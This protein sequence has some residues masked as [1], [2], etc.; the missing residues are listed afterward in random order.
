MSEQQFDRL[1]D[2]LQRLEWHDFRAVEKPELPHGVSPRDNPTPTTQRKMEEYR[3]ALVAYRDSLEQLRPGA[4]VFLKSGKFVLVGHVNES[5]TSRESY[6][7]DFE[8]E[9]ILKIAHLW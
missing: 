2:F 9:D 1:G 5:L 3:Q 6:E 8:P 7:P 4:V